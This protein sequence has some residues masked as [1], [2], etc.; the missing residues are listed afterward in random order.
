MFACGHLSSL[1]VTE[2]TNYSKELGKQVTENILVAGRLDYAGSIV[3]G[4]DELFEREFL[5]GFGD[6]LERL[7]D[8]FLPG[9][10][11]ARKPADAVN[12]F[13]VRLEVLGPTSELSEHG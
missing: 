4:L 5:Y 6:P 13:G 8:R 3:M 1:L 7:A 9:P 10:R 2:T 12:R 11:I